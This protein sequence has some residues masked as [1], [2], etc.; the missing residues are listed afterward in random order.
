MTQI[1]SGSAPWDPETQFSEMLARYDEALATASDDLTV[2]PEPFV[3]TLADA[4]LQLRFDRVHRCLQLLEQDRRRQTASSR[5]DAAAHKSISIP[6]QIGRFR[7]IR[8]LGSGGFG[9]VFLAEDPVLR[10]NVAIKIPLAT[11]FQ[12]QELHDRFL[13]ECRAAAMLNHPNIVRVLESGD[14]QGIPYQVAEYVNGERLSDLLQRQRPAVQLSVEIVR[15]MADAVQH[16]HDHGVLHRDIKPDNILLQNSAATVPRI[17]DFGLARV[18]DDNTALSRSGML[19]GT[20][21]Y[22]SPEQLHGQVRLQGPPTDIYSLGVVLHELLTGSVPFANADSLQSRMAISGSSVPSFRSART[23]ISKDLETVCLKCL[24]LRPED[25][26]ASAGDLRDDL[27]RY[28]DG[29]PT[30]AR[31]IPVHEQFVRWVAGNRKLAGLLGLLIVSVLVVLV[32]AIRNDRASRELNTTLTAALSQ[33]TEEKQRADASLNLA[34]QSGVKAQESESRY[35]ETAWLAQQGEFSA[36]MVHA[37]S[38]WQRGEIAPMNQTLLPFAFRNDGNSGGFVWRYL[39]NQG[40]VLRPLTGHS[41]FVQDLAIAAD[42]EHAWSIG[43]D[44]TIRRWHLKSGALEATWKLNGEGRVLRAAISQ[45]GRRAVISRVLE[46]ERKDDVAIWDL[47]T[48]RVIMSR[49]FAFRYIGAVAISNDGNAVLVGGQDRSDE[50]SL[51]PFVEVWFPDTDQVTHD[52]SSFRT[53]LVGETRVPGHAITEMS[54]SPDGHGLVIA[55]MGMFTPAHSQLLQTSLNHT[56]AHGPDQPASIFG[57]LTAIAWSRGIIRKM[58]FSPDGRYLAIVP[59]GDSSRAEVW[60][61]KNQALMQTT[62]D[63]VQP[64]G[65]MAFDASGTR[66]GL[67]VTV[68]TDDSEGRPAGPGRKTEVRTRSEFRLWD[69]VAHTTQT[70]PYHTHRTVEFLK[71]LN[72]GPGNGWIVG[73]GDGTLKVWQPGSVAPYR[74]WSGHRPSEVWDLAMSTDGSTVFSVGDDHCLRSWD[75]ASGVEKKSSSPR[76]SLVSCVAISPNGRWVASGGY[77]DQVNVYDTESLNPVATLCGHAHDLRALAFS[78]DSRLLATAGRD[79]I[80]RLWNVPG[81]D[82]AG[83]REGHTNA[84]RALTWT[85]DGQLISAGSDRRVLIWNSNGRVVR[86]RTEPDGIHSLA[87][88]PAGL[89]IPSPASSA[90]VAGGNSRTRTATGSDDRNTQSIITVQN[91]ELLALGMNHGTV[92]LWHLPTDTVLF[93]AQHPGLEIRSL[94]ISPDGRTLA[95]GGSEEAVY[96]WHVATGRNVLTFYQPGSSVHRVA[97]SPDGSHLLAALHDGTIRIWHAPPAP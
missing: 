93:D 72:S 34:K 15:C 37:S 36:A 26:Y 43:H 2:S 33:L 80:I 35:R 11:S 97:F 92:R 82:P 73:E 53:L 4:S 76:S 90:A 79:R 8:R 20:P 91:D 13:R 56:T 88:A 74:E 61:L 39:W 48:G 24:Q 77:D 52:D 78:P 17:T 54:F 95:V 32:Q 64:I 7:V 22:M 83:T 18:A 25:R 30:L 84:V 81:F 67:G 96:L 42:N 65:S 58:K 44:N 71:P 16:A 60:D 41:E 40:Q 31:P 14:V 85:T 12:S 89:R 57:P 75:R 70:L 46:R 50:N 49:E 21:K 45:D 47:N 27:S 38:S 63:F 3:S 59:S 29:R 9:V 55:V 5:Q 28:L 6:H 51:Q 66:L 87:F 94:A 19:V 69:F 86:E 62:E 68:P 10:R 23:G 1:P